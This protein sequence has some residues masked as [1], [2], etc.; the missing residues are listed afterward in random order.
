MP[1]FC[2]LTAAVSVR[3]F[4]VVGAT[5]TSPSAIVVTPDAGHIIVGSSSGGGVTVIAVATGLA[6]QLLPS[7][8][9]SLFA[10]V[11]ATEVCGYASVGQVGGLAVLPSSDPS[12]PVS[13][14]IADSGANRI[15][16][17]TVN[18]G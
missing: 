10:G 16:T 12:A 7:M 2:F 3:T 11:E 6:W 14:L 4:V 5:L 17:V 9:S 15:R 1:A 18:G 8:S 13:I